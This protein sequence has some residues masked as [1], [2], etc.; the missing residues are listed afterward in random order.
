MSQKV[1]AGA[2]GSTIRPDPAAVEG[3]NAYIQ[4][5][6]ALLDVEKTAVD[7]L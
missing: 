1:F 7:T 2:S 3:F 5:Y 6:K 4:R